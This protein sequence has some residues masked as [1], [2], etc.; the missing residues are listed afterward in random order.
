[1]S[2]VDKDSLDSS[3]DPR[4]FQQYSQILREEYINQD[5]VATDYPP[6]YGCDFFGRL[7]LL[8]IQDRFIRAQTASHKA[9][10]LLRGKIDKISDF[11][12]S[13]SITVED[14]LKPN[15]VHR[16]L[17]VVVDGPPG[18]GKTTLCR[19]ILNMWAKGEITYK[20][21]DVVLYCPLRNDTIAD[22]ESLADLFTINCSEVTSVV[23]WLRKSNGEGLLIIF[24]GWDELSEQHKKKSLA[25]KIIRREDFVKCSVIV[26]SRTYASASLLEATSV[27]RHVEVVGFSENEVK[28]VIK[29]T[30]CEETHQAQKLIEHLEVRGDALSLCY[31]PLICSIVIS[32]CR[33]KEQFPVTLTELYQ[34]FIIETIKR[35]AKIKVALK[36]EPSEIH[37]L[38]DLPEIIDKPLMEMS[39]LAY[40]GLTE[41]NPKMTFTI[42]QPQKL[43]LEEA[44]KMQYLGLMNT[45][46][47]FEKE[48]YQFLHL[49]VQEFLAAWWIARKNIGEEVFKN[50]HN[51][52]HLKMCLRFVAGLTHLKNMH[53]QIFRII[54]D[55]FSEP[56]QDI[57]SKTIHDK[58]PETVIEYTFKDVIMKLEEY[59]DFSK[60][61]EQLE[62]EDCGLSCLKIPH[63]GFYKSY[64]SRF[65]QHHKI[66]NDHQRIVYNLSNTIFTFQL[67]YEAQN[68]LYCQDYAQCQ[69]MIPSLCLYRQNLSPFDMLCV[70]YFLQNSNKAWNH[71]HISDPNNFKIFSDSLIN[72]SQQNSSCNILDVAIDLGSTQ[73][74]FLS[75]SFLC[76]ITECYC[77]CTCPGFNSCDD[78]SISLFIELIS[79]S[80]L[81][82]LVF[83]VEELSSLEHEA[84]ENCLKI[85]NSIQKN[86]V[87]EEMSLILGK[88]ST[89]TSAR[90]VTNVIKGMAM[91]TKVESFAIKVR[92]LHF[93]YDTS[94]AVVCLL[95]ENY[96]LKALK[97][98][99][100]F[101]FLSSE[102]IP[103][104]LEVNTPL[105]SLSIKQDAVLVDL[106]I[107]N[108]KSLQYLGCYS[109]QGTVPKLFQCH[110]C[111]QQLALCLHTTDSVIELFT[112]L[113]SNTT[114][115]AL[116]VDIKNSK[117][118]LADG[119][120]GI[121]L[122]NV[123]KENR[124]IQYLELIVALETNYIPNAFL[125]YLKAGLEHN[126]SLQ[127]VF[128]PLP[129][130]KKCARQI[131]NFFEVMSNRQ[132]LTELNLALFR[133]QCDNQS[134]D[135]ETAHTSDRQPSEEELT[136]LYISLLLPLLTNLLKKNIR[137]E[138]LR[139]EFCSFN[140]R[141]PEK[142][143]TPTALELIR[144]ACFH[145]SLKYFWAPRLSSDDEEYELILEAIR[146]RGGRI[147]SVHTV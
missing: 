89:T 145:P 75:S 12:K 100:P 134:T 26:T 85:K 98:F 30:L 1:M 121:S 83:E 116:R 7:K 143:K 47:M 117:N 60:F 115:T 129:L 31:I 62:I 74:K 105:N 86:C 64:I 22:A 97:L 32:V 28:K 3:L 96:T 124:K 38:E 108:C 10:Y 55:K 135:E 19:K 107:Q 106:I 63:F 16:S 6:R 147:P 11:D 136:K 128:I 50:Y 25:A 78:K 36:V 119:N 140:K 114:L 109:L 94:E 102:S 70:S 68:V 14:V 80:K 9:F 39:H 88:V 126:S 103:S 40:L 56:K 82:V 66:F 133:D 138:L 4:K 137:M 144:T 59:E 41:D 21:F 69:F 90:Y 123:I 84:S 52:D 67:L 101:V 130:S 118:I 27:D 125:P 139:I 23:K 111:L 46:S 93:Q 35:H 113:K 49:T 45:Y 91:N 2:D 146:T 37:S 92:K 8:D 77:V 51:N 104:A 71:L 87:L 112:I 81:K 34:D 54:N 79:L 120:V 65:H 95:K 142:G 43:H 61:D 53:N 122:Q 58:G 13:K 18:I 44:A 57:K 48:N 15:N 132:T 127:G 33:N 20:G 17:R 73:T 24:D 131:T 76:N 110:P 72:S 42:L 5:V 141:I 29:E 99:I